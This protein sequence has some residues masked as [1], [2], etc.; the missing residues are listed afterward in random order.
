MTTQRED[1]GKM[2]IDHCMVVVVKLNR[3]RLRFVVYL[4][5]AC[6]ATAV[7]CL[8]KLKEAVRQITRRSAVVALQ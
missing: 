2:Q 3:K 4:L 1:G 8:V 7:D 6:K 5:K